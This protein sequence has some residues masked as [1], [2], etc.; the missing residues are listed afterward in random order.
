MS[1]QAE[2]KRAIKEWNQT[3]IVVFLLR[4]NVQRNFNPPTASH[5]GG[6]W[7]RQIR[8][9]RNTL[10]G[11]LKLQTLEDEALMTLMCLVESIVN[12][13]PITKL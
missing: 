5:M 6:V 3:K 9:I 10:C 8:T 1:A 12:S 2:L 13:R 7:E 4:K 11:L